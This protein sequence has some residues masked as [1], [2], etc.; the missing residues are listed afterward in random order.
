MYPQPH[1]EL[2]RI[3]LVSACCQAYFVNMFFP[4]AFPNILAQNQIVKILG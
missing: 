3:V 2:F 1:N 4:L